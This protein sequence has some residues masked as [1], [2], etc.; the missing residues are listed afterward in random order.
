MLVIIVVVCR[1]IAVFFV[2]FRVFGDPIVQ[3]SVSGSI[4][5]G[6][7]PSGAPQKFEWSVSG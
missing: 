7:V 5:G 2:S 3:I 1:W 4:R 6:F